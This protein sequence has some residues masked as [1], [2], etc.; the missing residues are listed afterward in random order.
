M[1]Q[2]KPIAMRAVGHAI[3]TIRG[4]NVLLD[5]D[6]AGLYGVGTRVLNQAV[7]RNLERFPADFMFQLTTREAAILRSQS[8][9]SRRHGGHR[10]RPY[11][12]TEQGVAMLSGVLRSPRAVAVNVQVMRAFVQMRRT[13]GSYDGLVRRLDALEQRY[14]AQFA[15]VFRAI[16]SLMAPPKPPKRR[17]GFALARN[18][19][20]ALISMRAGSGRS[21][22]PTRE[23]RP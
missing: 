16:R 4:H 1:S 13:L 7:T 10:G 8:V 17:I 18:S 23:C 15:G 12:F 19:S 11:V 20:D 14:D 22:R 5:A 3:L 2:R 9:I 21:A 6:L